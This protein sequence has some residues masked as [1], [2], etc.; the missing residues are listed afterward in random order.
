MPILLHGYEVNICKHLERVS[1]IDSQYIVA[2]I[3]IMCDGTN[4]HNQRMHHL[5]ILINLM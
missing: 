2:I 5:E 1:S 3:V 4:I